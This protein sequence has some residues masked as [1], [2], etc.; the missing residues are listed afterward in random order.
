MNGVRVNRRSARARARLSYQLPKNAMLVGGGQGSESTEKLGQ[1]Q[2]KN[3]NP[4]N[5]FFILGSSVRFAS[6]LRLRV[7]R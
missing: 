2:N 4:K 1:N 5:N 6:G 7:S 3:A